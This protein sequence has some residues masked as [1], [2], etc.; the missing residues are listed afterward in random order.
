LEG[1]VEGVG[2]VDGVGKE[3]V[4]GDVVEGVELAAVEVVY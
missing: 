2:E 1:A 3:G 4:D